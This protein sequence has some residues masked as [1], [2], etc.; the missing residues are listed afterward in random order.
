VSDDGPSEDAL[1]AA[2]DAEAD[3]ARRKLANIEERR[4]LDQERDGL[5]WE[6][7]NTMGL[8]ASGA[9]QAIRGRL[10][11]EG[12]TPEEINTLGVSLASLRPIARLRRKP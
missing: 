9:V 10:L 5:Y 8:T 3:W 2:L 6:L 1:R 11:A 12:F 7:V 4:D